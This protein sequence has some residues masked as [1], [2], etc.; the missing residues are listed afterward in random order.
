MNQAK[1]KD[2]RQHFDVVVLGA[3]LAGLSLCRQLLMSTGKRVLLLEKRSQ[4]PPRQQKVG[5][6]LV[7]VAGYYFGRVLDLE[8]YLLCNHYMKYNLRFYWKSAARGNDG[9]EDYSQAYIRT[10]SNIGCYQLDRNTLEGELLRLNRQSDRFAYRA[11]V[12]LKAVELAEG[13]REPHLIRFRQDGAEV[14]VTAQWVVDCTGRNRF[15]ARRKK[16]QEQNAIRH[17]A[18]FFW[19]DGLVNIDKLTCGDK[20]QVRLKRQ[21]RDQGHLPVWLATNH[22]CGEGFWFWVIPLQGK[23]SLGLVYDKRLISHDQVAGAKK[24][25]DWVCREFPLFAHDLPH[26]KVLDEAWLK[27][28][29]YGCRQ[30]ID[31]GRWA[32]AGESGRFTDPLYS[33][34]SDL[35][36]IYNT[37]IVDAVQ[38]QD[39][40]E[41]AAKCHLYEQLM[42]TVYDAYVPAY[43]VSYDALGDQECFVLKYTWELSVYFAFYVFP[44]INDLLTD[45]EFLIPFFNRFGRL[46]P[47]NRGLQQLLSDF[48][49]WKK[50]HRAP[51]SEPV[52]HEFTDIPYLKRSEEA[53]YKVGLTAE[54]AVQVLKDQ[55]GHLRELARFTVAHVA[56]VVLGEPRAAV[57]RQFVAG[58][59]LKDI[60]FDPEEMRS[61]YSECVGCLEDYP[62]PFDPGVMDVFRTEGPKEGEPAKSTQSRREILA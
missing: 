57:N 30:T 7:Q 1:P 43:A 18:S 10:F 55:L 58:I 56:S 14:S 52:F 31:A 15:L 13:V 47:V 32:L 9:F 3:G 33:P 21:R 61:R 53:F 19:V 39:A 44:F 59:D 23:T 40:A 24:L 26:R 11:P 5:E 29:S 17:G 20:N 42:R 49:Q 45:R 37:L 60:R 50:A 38:T 4:I 6:S 36:S 16:L 12:R 54:E 35:I 41:L 62:W 2:P 51:L 46:G 8:E 28:Y 27:D 34:G 25:T 22:F 48:C